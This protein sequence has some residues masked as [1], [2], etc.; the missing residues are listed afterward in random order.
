MEI[1]IHLIDEVKGEDSLHLEELAN[2]LEQDYDLK[3]KT[4]RKEADA[5]S[6]D[7]GLTIALALSIA[8]VGISMVNAIISGLSYW[9]SQHPNYSVSFKA[10]DKTITVNQVD[11]K[12]IDEVVSELQKVHSAPEIVIVKR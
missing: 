11:P 5:G 4:I 2:I 9:K 6:K 12:K 8:S 10:G 1:N 3:V 7:G